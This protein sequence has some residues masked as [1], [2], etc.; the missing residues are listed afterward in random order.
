MQNLTCMTS[1]FFEPPSTAKHS[2]RFAAHKH[3]EIT[4][5]QNNADVWEQ[6]SL[7]ATNIIR[8]KVRIIEPSVLTIVTK[9][10]CRREQ[11]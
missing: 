11:I 6:P 9:V 5:L 2:K 4:T 7:R 3:T 10:T 1:P 8:T